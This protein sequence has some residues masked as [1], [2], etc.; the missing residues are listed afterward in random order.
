M[1]GTQRLARIVWALIALGIVVRLVRYLLA[2]PLWPDETYLACNFLDRGYIELMKPLDFA[3]IAPL[4]YLWVQETFIRALGFSEYTLRLYVL[5]CGIGSLFVFRH[6]A[7]RL[8][9]GTAFLLAVGTFSVAYPL[10]RHSA[11]AKPYGSDMFVSL[12]LLAL[13]VEWARRPQQRRGG[14][15]SAWPCRW[16]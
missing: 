8:L 6:L 1:L 7:G 12:V 16:P 2:F 11:E 9:R 5:L 4:L 3:Q 13:A 15:P 10:V 14:G